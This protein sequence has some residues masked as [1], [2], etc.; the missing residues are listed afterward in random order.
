MTDGNETKHE[1]FVLERFLP[2]LLNQAAEASSRSFQS[3]YRSEYGMTRT[4]WRVMANIGRFGA[5]TARDICLRTHD[6]KTL[7]SRAVAALEQRGFLT[8]AEDARDRRTEILSLTDN[9]REVFLSLGQ[10]ALSYD[11]NLRLRLGEQG[12]RELEELLMR[13]I[14]EEAPGFLD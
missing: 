14:G 2:Y 8:R 9:G 4:Q 11:H 10:Q 1:E 12:T 3:I 5:M 7:V 6:E 13:L